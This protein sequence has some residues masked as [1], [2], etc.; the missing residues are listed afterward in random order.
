[1]AQEAGRFIPFER[2]LLKQY[3]DTGSSVVKNFFDYLIEKRLLHLSGLGWFL[4][5]D[6]IV[7]PSDPAC[8]N[9]PY[10]FKCFF[11]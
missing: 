1:M 6:K 11:G 3:Q 5:N 8:P 7:A 2:A 9:C 4:S 10:K